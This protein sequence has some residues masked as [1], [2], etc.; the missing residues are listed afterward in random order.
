MKSSTNLI[1]IERKLFQ[2]ISILYIEV[3]NQKFYNRSIW[4][5]FFYQDLKWKD[6]QNVSKGHQVNHHVWFVWTKNGIKLA[7]EQNDEDGEW[8]RERERM[9]IREREREERKMMRMENEG[10]MREEDWNDWHVFGIEI[11]Q[12]TFLF[13]SFWLKSEKEKWE[14]E[15]WGKREREREISA[16][17]SEMWSCD[18]IG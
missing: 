3:R 16:S 1:A 2:N 12:L 13:V 6:N 15:K 7:E 17:G 11:T 10:L 4:E 18:K 9:R 5:R 14:E 8:Q